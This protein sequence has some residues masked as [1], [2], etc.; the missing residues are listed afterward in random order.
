[1]RFFM[2]KII[3]ILSA[4]YFSF[5]A[6]IFFSSDASAYVDPTT[7]AML[8]QIVAG[9]FISLG[10]TLG[11]FRRKITMFFQKLKVKLFQKKI[12]EEKR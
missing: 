1:M 5:W 7:T 6:A 4:V 2:E 10:L 8:T 9:I 12:G 3:K 11:I